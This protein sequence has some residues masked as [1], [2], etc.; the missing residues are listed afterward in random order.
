MFVPSRNRPNIIE[1]IRTSFNKTSKGFAELLIIL[2]EDDHHRYHRHHDL[3]YEIYKGEAG[4]AQEKM[5]FFA[6]EY[7]AKYKYIGFIGDDNEFVTE[8]WDGIVYNRLNE[9]GKYSIGYLNDLMAEEGKAQLQACRNVIISSNIIQKLSYMAPPCLRHFY[10]DN[11]WYNIGDSLGGLVYFDDVIVKHNH[12]LNGKSKY[13]K[14]YEIAY[15][16]DKMHQDG[17]RYNDYMLNEFE[18]DLKKLK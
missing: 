5:N 3:K 15:N 12:F 16:N 4:Y 17:V 9:V 14:I 11:F 1:K 8:G 13:D 2:D 18:N 10:N 6:T 7:A